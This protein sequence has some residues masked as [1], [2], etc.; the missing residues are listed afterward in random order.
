MSDKNAY[1]MKK[2]GKNVQSTNATCII[3]SSER[4]IAESSE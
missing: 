2:I 4:R 1:K 3:R